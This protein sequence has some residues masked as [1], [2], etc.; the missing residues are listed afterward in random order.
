MVR[1]N[2]ERMPQIYQMNLE[3]DELMEDEDSERY[4]FG[5]VTPKEENMKMLS[6][7]LGDL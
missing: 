1:D 7:D 4:T 2:F 5:Y 3:D 6:G